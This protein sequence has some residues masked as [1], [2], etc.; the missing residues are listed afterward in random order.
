MAK[1]PLRDEAMN[2]QL[3]EGTFSMGTRQKKILR[4]AETNGFTINVV[5]QVLMQNVLWAS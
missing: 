1:L 3:E 5:H 4:K 2:R